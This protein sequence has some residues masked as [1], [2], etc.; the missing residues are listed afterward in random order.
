MPP[1]LSPKVRS[2]GQLLSDKG[3]EVDWAAIVFV[4]TKV[5][6]PPCCFHIR[7]LSHT[8]MA[9]GSLV[10]CFAC[11]VFLLLP[12]S[13]A[14]HTQLT[15]LVLYKLLQS[16][17]KMSQLLKAGYLV[18]DTEAGGGTAELGM[19]QAVSLLMLQWG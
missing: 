10:Q 2:V 13:S 1:L 18:G 9:L 15:A 4:E 11:C 19:S 3:R 7:S 17:P 14:T 12:L 5:R 8:S 6:V 16:C